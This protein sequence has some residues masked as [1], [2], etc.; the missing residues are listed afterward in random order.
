MRIYPCNKF[1]YLTW[2]ISV[3]F[4]PKLLLHN[5]KCV[6]TTLVVLRWILLVTH[7]VE[8]ISYRPPFGFEVLT[9]MSLYSRI[10]K[11]IEKYKLSIF[12]I[13]EKYHIMF[14]KN[15]QHFHKNNKLFSKP[16]KE[17]LKNT[18]NFPKYKSTI[19][20]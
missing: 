16:W 15:S 7:C 8:N 11:I 13:T 20:Y 4:P 5:N 6:V 3:F 12:Y 17:C 9:F 14:S 1:R 10:H 2:E 19:T 18:S